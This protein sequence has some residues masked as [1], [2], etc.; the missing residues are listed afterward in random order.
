[1]GAS[2]RFI[3]LLMTKWYHN[4][5][6]VLRQYCN[7]GRTKYLPGTPLLYITLHS[8]L[9]MHSYTTHEHEFNEESTLVK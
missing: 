3:L 8:R 5:H 6:F 9:D 1:M 4:G 2:P 7:T